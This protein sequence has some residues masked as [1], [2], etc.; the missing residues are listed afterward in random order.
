MTVLEAMNRGCIP[1]IS[2]NCG[3]KDI[4]EDDCGLIY[5]ET[6]DVAKWIKQIDIENESK[7]SFEISLRNTYL[8]MAGK[9]VEKMECIDE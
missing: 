7:K 1:I 5:K 6:M 3:V 4:L 9:Y 8:E 2:A